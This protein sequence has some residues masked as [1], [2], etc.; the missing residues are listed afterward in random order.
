MTTKRQ[1]EKAEKKWAPT[2][3]VRLEPELAERLR[4][5]SFIHRVKKQ[6]LLRVA[7]EKLL[8]RENARTA[9]GIRKRWGAI[10]AGQPEHTPVKEALI[11]TLAQ[12]AA[13]RKFCYEFRMHKQTVVREALVQYLTDLDA[14]AAKRKR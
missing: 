7:L 10:A 12:D 14:A 8:A 1:P 5:A 11:L 3:T 2:F 6:P 13:L 9:A 4:V